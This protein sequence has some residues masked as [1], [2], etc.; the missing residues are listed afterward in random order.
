MSDEPQAQQLEFIDLAADIVS[1]YVSKNNVPITELPSLIASV[2]AAL[3]GLG[4]PAAIPTEDHK[5]TA[6]QIRKSI[7]P[8]AIVSFIDGK[9]YKSLKR[10][11]TSNGTTPD[12]YR[13][14]Y[15]L[16][17]DYPMVAASY[18]ARRSELA[19]SLGL[20]QLRRDLAAAK[21]AAE[22]RTEPDPVVTA[23]VD[24]KPARRGRPNK[25]EANT[26]E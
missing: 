3:S 5:V 21:R 23:P 13:Q 20:G 25:A 14:K 18:T 15:G 22:K 6:A 16:P 8:D 11:L 1:A 17:R 12:E 7:T 4:Q 26:A 10:H 24:A 19:K 2:H 9:S